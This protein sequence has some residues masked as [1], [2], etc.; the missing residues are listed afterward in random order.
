MEKLVAQFPSQLEDALNIQSN[1]QFSKEGFYPANIVISGL[2]GSAIGGGIVKDYVYPLIDMPIYVNRHYFLP[3]YVKEN[4]LLIICS[5]SGNTE[6]TIS[7]LEDGILKKANIVCIASGGKIEQIAK[8]KGLNLLKLPEGFQPRAALGYIIAQMLF[9]LSEVKVIGKSYVEEIK[10]AIQLLNQ[11]KEYIQEHSK[12]LAVDLKDKF[13][14]LYS[15]NAIQDITTRWKQQLN[16]NAKTLTWDNVF[17]EMNHNEIVGWSKD[18]QDFAV[19]ILRNDNDFGRIQQRMELTMTLIKKCT[20]SVFEVHSKGTNFFERALYLIHYGDWL[21]L[22]LAKQNGVDANDVE[23]IDFI[24][25][26][27]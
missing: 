3:A 22:H 18:L 8:E 24:K 26:N 23:N 6:E 25:K 4:T 10:S 9:V 19:I 5:Y 1:L 20:E 17:P 13:P 15:S 21:S 12:Q 16:E 2:G 11:E 14:I 27:L 7:A